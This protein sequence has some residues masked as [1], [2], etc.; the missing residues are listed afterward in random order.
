[1]RWWLLV[2]AACSSSST[3]EIVID[4]RGAPELEVTRAFDVDGS[5]PVRV[6]GGAGHLVEA[7][8]DDARFADT[9]APWFA[10]RPVADELALDVAGDGPVTLTVW[11]RGDALPPVARDRSLAWFDGALLDD[12]SAISFAKVMA[13]VSPDGRGGV[14]FEKLF[15]AFAAGPGAGR[16]TFAQFLDGVVAAQ[17]SDA[18]QWNLD[19]LPF[20]VT[21]VHDRVDLASGEH[22][23]ELRV[24]I[25]STHATFSPVHFIF[26]F[27][28]PP[29]A[30]DVTPDGVVHCRGTARAWSRLTA[31]DEPAF[32]AAAKQM[33]T[34]GI[35]RDRFLLAESVELSL[36][37][38]QWRQ[39]ALD[40]GGTF[41]NPPLFQTIDIAR[42]NAP[43]PTRDAFLAAVTANAPAIA[44][45]TWSVPP[46]FRSAVAE[47][48]PNSKAPLADLAPLSVSP[49][50]PRALGMIGCPRCHTDDADFI[51]TG[52]D[53]KP[54]PF[55]DQELDARAARLDA[56]GRGEAPPA[57]PFGP[58]QPL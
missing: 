34:A 55:Y 49:D 52:V 41:T 14:V 23:G 17:G 46:M 33:L 57:P 15:R 26:L 11:T 50:L 53:R 3:G 38:W 45:R 31:L 40:A 28:Q 8:V 43:G 54:S 4:L 27:R 19:A 32:R 36:S 42:V 18:A 7:F 37:P 47:V 12:T 16:A 56:L 51:Q 6:I 5:R 58:L 48:Q 22:C 2:L 1:M 44:A 20:K 25:A 30:D 29:R 24:S 10:P 35:V 13:A 39:W 9:D 21:G